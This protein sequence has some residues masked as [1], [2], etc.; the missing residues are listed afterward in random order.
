MRRH[1]FL[2]KPDSM[3]QKNAKNECRPTGRHVHD[4][5]AGKIDGGDFRGRIPDSIHPPVDPPD[6][7]C[8]WEIDGEHPERD[9]DEHGR[10]FHSLG[11]CA[12][13]QC[14]RDDREH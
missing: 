1:D 5:S 12:N 13:D 8:D 10:E 11:N 9:E 7:M 14:R 3:A 4:R 6:H 2:S